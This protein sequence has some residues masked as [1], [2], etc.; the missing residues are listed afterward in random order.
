MTNIVVQPLDSVVNPMSC[1][2]P[3]LPTAADVIVIQVV[4]TL[5]SQPAKV[6]VEQYCIYSIKLTVTNDFYVLQCIE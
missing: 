3:D 2:G 1:L 4:M 6:Y 5:K